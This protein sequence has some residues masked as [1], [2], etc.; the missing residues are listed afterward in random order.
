LYLLPST[1]ENRAFLISSGINDG[2][3]APDTLRADALCSFA[4]SKSSFFCIHQHNMLLSMLCSLAN[5]DKQ[6]SFCSFENFSS[7][8][9]FSL[10]VKDR[11]REGWNFSGLARIRV[12]MIA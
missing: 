4:A 1:K 12:D 6:F 7:T 9:T 5:L 8:L 2:R 3:P 11:Q 10:T